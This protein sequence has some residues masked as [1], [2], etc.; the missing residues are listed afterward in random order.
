[1]STT[2]GVA[3]NRSQQHHQKHDISLKAIY[4][5]L[6]EPHTAL[7]VRCLAKVTNASAKEINH[8]LLKLIS[9]KKHQTADWSPRRLARCLNFI[10][11]HNIKPHLQDRSGLPSFK[12]CLRWMLEVL[13]NGM[14]QPAVMPPTT[15]KQG[16]S[17]TTASDLVMLQYAAKFLCNLMETIALHGNDTTDTAMDLRAEIKQGQ[18]LRALLYYCQSTVQSIRVYAIRG[19]NAQAR[20]FLCDLID[21]DA[22]DILCRPLSTT[23]SLLTTLSLHPPV[24]DTNDKR[25][26]LSEHLLFC[27]LLESFFK[28]DTTA[29][30]QEQLSAARLRFAKSMNCTNIVFLWKDICYHEYKRILEEQQ[31]NKK[32]Q[33][34]KPAINQGQQQFLKNQRLLMYTL[35]TIVQKC[36]RISVLAANNAAKEYTLSRWIPQLYI[37]MS[38]WVR[39]TCCTMN[40]PLLTP[41][42]LDR[43]KRLIV[44][45]LQIL[46]DTL[47]IIRSN[48]EKPP[49]TDDEYTIQ[50]NWQCCVDTVVS[51][52]TNFFMAFIS[53]PIPPEQSK[54]F[55]EFVTLT[56]P[57][58]CIDV[59]ERGYQLD[60]T[61]LN[62]THQDLIIISL[63]SLIQ[64]IQLAT[65]DCKK[66]VASRV[67][68]CL[69]SMLTILLNA[70][71]LP[72]SPLQARLSKLVVFF[73]HYEEAITMFAEASSNIAEYIWTPTIQMAKHGLLKAVSLHSLPNNSSNNVDSNSLSAE[74]LSIISKAKRAFLALE[75]VSRQPR[76]CERLVD[77]QVLQLIDVKLIPSITVMER[78]APLLPLYA[79]FGRFVAALSRR[80]AFVRTR[81]RDEHTFFPM[82]IKLLEGAIRLKEANR[83]SL[84]AHPDYT[85]GH[86]DD[87]FEI[88]T[89]SLA[90]NDLEERV[91]SWNHVITSCLL[92]ISSFEFDTK[93]MILWLSFNLAS[94]DKVEGTPDEKQPD[95][96]NTSMK[97]SVLPSLLS[98]LLPWRKYDTKCTIAMIE[99]A[100]KSDD[101]QLISLAAH[102]LSLFAPISS[103]TKQLILDPTALSDIGQLIVIVGNI[104]FEDFSNIKFVN[105]IIEGIGVS[106]DNN[107][108]EVFTKDSV[109]SSN[110]N[111]SDTPTVLSGNR[112]SDNEDIKFDA[113]ISE[114][115]SDSGNESRPIRIPFNTFKT[116]TAHLLRIAVY[117]LYLGNNLPLS[118]T[119]NCFTTFFQQL[120]Q[121]SSNWF[122]REQL[123]HS[124]CSHFCNHRMQK[125][126]DLYNFTEPAE[127]SLKLHEM[128]AI[129]LCYAVIGSHS[130]SDY[131]NRLLGL[132]EDVE[133]IL[134]ANS[135]FSNVCQMLVY[136]LIYE[137]D[138]DNEELP[139]MQIESD[140][141]TMVTNLRRDAA[142]QVIEILAL[143]FNPL[144]N[145]ETNAIPLVEVIPTP[146]VYDGLPETVHFVTDDAAPNTYIPGTR[147]LLRARSAIFEALLST[148]YV[149]SQM[150]AIPIHDIKFKSLQQFI[151]VI[152]KLNN[153]KEDISNPVEYV[154]PS[155]TAWQ[156]IIELIT[157]SD[158][159]GSQH[160]K[161]LCEVW[162]I[163][164]VQRI[165]EHG[166]NNGKSNMQSMDLSGMLTLF[167]QCHDAYEKDGG[168]SSTTWP[169]TMVLKE[170]LKC[171]L[172]YMSISIQTLDFQ[173]MVQEE[174][175]E[176]LSIFCN[177]IAKLLT[178]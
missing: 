63:E 10:F 159:F 78:Y 75:L 61:K 16:H 59:E 57:H 160:V 96:N 94:E 109:M 87:S 86:S 175:D 91:K 166:Y 26:E 153:V 139:Q 172:Q 132:N 122:I 135:V 170:T 51:N 112:A 95:G 97:G 121:H 169:F 171:V 161:T 150:N 158:R 15:H 29:T 18:G 56:H 69:K 3:E 93:S 177:S 155:S 49:N 35:T 100:L 44:K 90:L 145:T 98:I 148:D 55:G 45:L 147:Q 37:S 108:V 71:L 140:K 12:E 142:A 151:D 146:I 30:Q 164:K 103:C 4:K 43:E 154:L 134:D 11:V 64:T 128:T 47:P 106:K 60:G 110:G 27:R 36:T 39:D 115:G 99:T 24:T 7:G 167:R 168:I 114:S 143:N 137:E 173:F 89:R 130:D 104:C 131:W 42:M 23:N 138:Y 136:E 48:L 53:Q 46:L 162:I 152:D 2:R 8:T 129:A 141:V 21:L 116:L 13:R 68:W 67:A 77:C 113:I 5:T 82:I 107:E 54:M 119:H 165:Q 85:T 105:S 79:L 25:A 28:Y 174:K 32:S 81:L 149:E 126:L 144:W 124:I 70:N 111:E 163:K 34:G 178:K 41:V 88:E 72:D 58:V 176:E 101:I 20:H 118:L 19:L 50:Y 102:V 1:M 65:S 40:T 14:D 157:I 133:S 84:H 80:M 76:A 38:R 33:T 31:H 127:T 9:Y 17:N 74:D 6:Q 123:I 66:T 62:H 73:L 22:F 92:V 156:D 83:H 125:L 52:L 120:L 117:T